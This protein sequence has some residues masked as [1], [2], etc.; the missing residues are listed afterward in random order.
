MELFYHVTRDI[1]LPRP[2]AGARVAPGARACEACGG[3]LD[4]DPEATGGYGLSF[5]AECRERLDRSAIQIHFCDECGVSVPRYAIEHGQA[6]AG[7][8]RIVC[9]HCRAT[10]G[11]RRR[12]RVLLAVAVLAALAL[13]VGVALAI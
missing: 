4:S 3:Q 1:E 6:L 2:T 8:G 9:G 12:L 11:Q 10:V 13:G 5:C 7:D